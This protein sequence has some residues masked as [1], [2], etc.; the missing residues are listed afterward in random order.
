MKKF[1]VWTI[2]FVVILFVGY[3]L[4]HLLQYITGAALKRTVGYLD[5][6]DKKYKEKLEKENPPKLTVKE[7][8]NV[9][10]E[11]EDDEEKS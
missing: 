11:E 2:I 5:D 8:E 9:E 10:V 4:R 1:I 6:L 7:D 3:K